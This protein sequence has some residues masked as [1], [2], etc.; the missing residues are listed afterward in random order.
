MNHQAIID[1]LMHIEAW[2]TGLK[3]EATRT[4]KELERQAAPAP[5]KGRKKNGL[6]EEEQKKIDKLLARR[7]ARKLINQNKI[8]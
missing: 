4:R 3:E 2:A 5:R 6:T 7:K 1:R 8:Q